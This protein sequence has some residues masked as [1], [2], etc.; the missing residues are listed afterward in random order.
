M[1]NYYTLGLLL[2]VQYNMNCILRYYFHPHTLVSKLVH[3]SLYIRL[4]LVMVLSVVLGLAFAHMHPTMIRLLWM[5]CLL[6]FPTMAYL[7]RYLGPS[8]SLVDNN[9]RHLFQPSFHRLGIQLS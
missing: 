7:P 2:T 3:A 8:L 4:G 6:L 1:R 5:L 9:G